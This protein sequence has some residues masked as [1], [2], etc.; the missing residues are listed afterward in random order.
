MVEGLFVGPGQ[1]VQGAPLRFASAVL[2][3]LSADAARDSELT[4][5]DLVQVATVNPPDNW[6]WAVLSD[7]GRYGWGHTIGL[8]LHEPWRFVTW[9]YGAPRTYS[10]AYGPL[11]ANEDIAA[12]YGPDAAGCARSDYES[13]QLLLTHVP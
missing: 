13:I 8:D 7:V 10:V 9:M 2:P 3:R 11:I 6:A 4:C 1:V 12:A 5:L